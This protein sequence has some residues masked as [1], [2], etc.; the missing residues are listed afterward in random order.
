MTKKQKKEIARQLTNFFVEFWKNRDFLAD[1]LK[2]RTLK[3]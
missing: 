1:S 3:K 2:N